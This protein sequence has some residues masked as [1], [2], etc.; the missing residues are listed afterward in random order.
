MEDGVNGL[1][2]PPGDH[3]A[4][5]SGI[6]RLLADS[7]LAA[8]LGAAARQSVS[9]RFSMERM[10]SDTERLYHSLLDARSHVPAVANGELACK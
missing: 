8:R 5:A 4:L 9:E 7:S 10:V 6:G 3:E 1:L 2:V